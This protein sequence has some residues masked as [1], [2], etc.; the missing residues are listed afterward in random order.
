MDFS[1]LNNFFDHIYVLTLERATDRQLKMKE[2]LEDLNYTFFIGV[3]KKDLTIDELVE[4]KIYD[5]Q[6]AISLHRFGKPMNTGQIG[7]AWSHRLLY[8]DMV[9]NK[10][11]KVLI[12]EDDVVP[13]KEGFNV[14]EK[15]IKDLP[16]NWELW[17]L[18]YHKNLRRNFGTWVKQQGYHLQ[19]LAGKLK[20]SHKTINNFYARKFNDHLFLAGFHELTSA[21]AITQTAAKKLIEL[22]TPVAF[23]ADDLLAHACSNLIIYGFASCPK[24]FL[25]E[26]Q[27]QDKKTRASYAEE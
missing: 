16:S 22:Q 26:S 11:Q 1:P 15:M 20:W 17:Y 4:N 7:C 25:Q 9:K 3:D 23:V 18:D 21:Y 27:L 24:V 8:E 5:E 13:N 6:K 14:L 19:R 12:L 10:Y 2:V